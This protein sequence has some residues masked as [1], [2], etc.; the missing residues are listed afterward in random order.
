MKKIGVF[1]A[2]ILAISMV[3]SGCGNNTAEAQSSEQ[4]ESAVAETSEQSRSDASAEEENEQKVSSLEDCKLRLI[5]CHQIQQNNEPFTYLAFALLG[6]A[7][8]GFQLESATSEISEVEVSEAWLEI[9]H[10]G[11]GWRL[12]ICKELPGGITPEDLS[13]RITDYS[14]S[15]EKNV[16]LSDWGD[17]MSKEELE[18]IGVHEIEG[19]LVV[20]SQGSPTIVSGTY[21]VGV[22][23][24]LIGPEFGNP[25]NSFPQLENPA[26]VFHFY[27]SDGTPLAQKVG[28]EMDCYMIRN[29]IYVMFP[30]EEGADENG[31]IEK[32]AELNP[33]MEYT[34]GAGES[35]QFSLKLN[36]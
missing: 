18:T 25:D 12:V 7:D 9:N 13:L 35:F 2:G 6:P 8:I 17:P 1:L 30:L 3:L 24:G 23:L 36:E 26:D 31:E 21:G 27:A 14:T 33:Y 22:W 16:L 19:H 4:Q 15:E 29:G 34:N 32:L 11:G 5:D 20:V 10:M 28:K